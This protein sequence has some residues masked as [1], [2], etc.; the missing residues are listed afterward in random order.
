[1][2]NPNQGTSRTWLAD[3]LER[4]GAA[5]MLLD[6]DLSQGLGGAR[7]AARQQRA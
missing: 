5:R 3:A 1:M 4:G 2:T 6:G 7:V